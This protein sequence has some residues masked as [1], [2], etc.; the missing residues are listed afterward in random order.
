M[1]TISPERIVEQARTHLG[2]AGPND[3]CV[4][5]GMRR[6]TRELGL[7]DI[8]TDSVGEARRLAKAGHNGWRY[9][10][11]MH[12]VVPGNFLD[13]DPDVLDSPTDA[14]VS[15]LESIA[16]G[17]FRSIG[18]GGPSGKVALQPQSGGYNPPDYFR[19]YFVAPSA[20]PAAAA[21]A[22]PAA[23]PKPASSGRVDYTVKPKDNLTR[24]AA[25]HA[26]SVA[27]ILRL[28]PANARRTT[29]DYSIPHANLILVGQRIRIR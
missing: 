28:N 19:G 1:A 22:K 7:A 25:A 6:W 26:T 24:I 3:S 14:H 17:D 4:S 20:Q 27:A 9:V 23:A 29:A 2:E 8:G 5:N 15:V 21:P 13:W 12:G 16:H 18:S 11:G 10:A